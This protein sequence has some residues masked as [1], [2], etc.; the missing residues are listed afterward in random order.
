[1]LLLAGALAHADPCKIELT[2]NDQMQFN[3]RELVVPTDCAEV[4]VTLRHSG[5]LPARSMGHDWVLAKD[6]DMSAIVT[7]GLAAGP[8]RGYLPEHD[9]RIIAATPIVGGGES[10]TVKFAT[11]LLQAGAR[12]AFFCTSPG[13]STVMR[14]TFKFGGTSRLVRASEKTG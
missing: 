2:S 12:Y 6:S 4:E 14:G 1:M 5:K 8:A 11:S 10:A 7:A 3:V 9:A 13:H